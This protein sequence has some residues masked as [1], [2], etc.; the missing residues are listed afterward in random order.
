MKLVFIITF[1]ILLSGCKSIE[2]PANI[3]IAGFNSQDIQKGI[4]LGMK[5]YDASEEI[6]PEQEYYIGRSVAASILNKYKIYN[7]TKLNSYVTSIGT[8]LAMHS[9]RPEIFGGYHFTVLDSD[10][11][12]AFATP[13]GFIF[14]TRG[15]INMKSHIYN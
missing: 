9:P 10:E 8:L 13:G 15:M 12:N 11:I 3:S 6:T 7:N 1:F 4:N 14:I 5:V 2:V